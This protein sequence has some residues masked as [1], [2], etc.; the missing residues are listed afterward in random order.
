MLVGLFVL[1]HLAVGV[2]N[3]RYDVPMESWRSFWPTYLYVMFG[4]GAMFLVWITI[5]GFRD[6]F[7]LFGSLRVEVVDKL[8]DGR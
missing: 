2:Y 1:L 5:G 7:R 3:F 4:L 8:D 6:L